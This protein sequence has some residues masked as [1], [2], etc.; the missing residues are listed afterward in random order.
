ML[1]QI[2]YSG[3]LN[4]CQAIGLGSW[5]NCKLPESVTWTLED[6]IVENLKPLGI[7]IFHNLPFGHGHENWLWRANQ[8]YELQ[9]TACL[10]PFLR[11]SL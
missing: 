4:G 6:L 11:F 5:S 2:I 10:S 8:I 3:M 1:K 9:E 7:P